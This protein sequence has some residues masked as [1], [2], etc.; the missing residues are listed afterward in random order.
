MRTPAGFLLPMN[1]QNNTFEKPPLSI[2]AQLARLSSRGVI[3]QDQKA[4][5]HYLTYISYYRF[6]GYAI[7]FEDEP[8]NG[9]KRYRQGTTFE[10]ILDSYVFDRKLRLLVIDAIERIEIAIRT[11]MTNELGLKHGAHWYLDQ[12]LFLPRFRYDE[13]IQAIKKETQYKAQDGSIQHKKREPFIQHY[14]DKY[15]NPE[16]PAIWMVAEVLPL[17]SWSMIFANL[18]DRENQKIICKYFD[19]YYLVM[20]SWLHSLS[21]LRNLCA[22]HSKIWNRSFTLKP[23]VVNKYQQQL[24]NNTRFSAQ[25]AILKIFLD[26]ISPGSE[27]GN[28]LRSLIKQHPMIDVKRMGFN[29]GWESDPFWN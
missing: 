4:A 19:I 7:E 22:H 12:G 13:L 9:E 25:A 10:K 1:N 6:C 15:P 26:V 14:Y 20:T 28:N 8:I 5:Q 2:E 29:E 17:G 16:L 27:W 3:I 18:V 23:A 21:Y 11:V 24:K